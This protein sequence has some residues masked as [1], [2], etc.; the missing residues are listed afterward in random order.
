MYI[1]KNALKN[2]GRNKDRNILLGIIIFVVILS[3]TV[4]LVI[5]TTSK[6]IIEDYKTRFGSKVTL[7]VDFDKLMADQKPDANGNFMFPTAPEISSQQYLAFADS[8]YLKSY[9]MDMLAGVTFSELKAVDEAANEGMVG[10]IGGSSDDD[11]ISPKAKLLG[12]SDPNNLPHF[13]DGLRK[14]IKGN[15]YQGKNDCLVSSDFA[16]LNKLDVGDTFQVMDTASKKTVTL[17]VAGIYA[18]ATKESDLPEGVISFEG[19]Y[20][21]RRNE[22][23]VSMDTMQ[24][25]FD[26]GS[27]TVNAAYELKSP[28]LL[29]GFE[30]ELREKG[31]PAAYMVETDEAGYNKIVAPVVGLSKISMT[32]MWV[33]LV[34]GG[35]ILLFITS[36]AIR[37]RKYEIGVL[38]AMGMKKAKVAVML[39]AETVMITVLCLTAGLGI[40]NAISQPIADS[41][42]AGQVEAAENVQQ[43]GITQNPDGSVNI[44][45]AGE[46]DVEPLSEI[47]VALTPEAALQIMLIALALALLSSAAGVVFI[48]KY[49]PMKILSE[50]N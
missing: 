50:R 28:D 19:S 34:V 10:S 25:N 30:K 5:N 37:E 22:I 11:Y 48:T 43:G 16:D 8:D 39:V 42:I 26:M 4:A 35:V 44:G 47:D 33:I 9:Q 38:R 45:G 13:V 31:L 24:D 12:Y 27:L 15:L 32:F 2:L 6:N 46:P 14:I 20:G 40:G 41:L 49:E 23:L 17:K 29:D 21:N 18:D 7:S 1:L 36:M 3:T